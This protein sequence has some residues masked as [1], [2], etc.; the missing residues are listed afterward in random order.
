MRPWTAKDDRDLV[1]CYVS[2]LTTHEIAEILLRSEPAISRRLRDQHN[3]KPYTGSDHV[4]A[5]GWRGGGQRIR[6]AATCVLGMDRD[7]AI[8]TLLVRKNEVLECY[9]RMLDAPNPGGNSDARNRIREVIADINNT[10]EAL[11]EQ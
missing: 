8:A 10:I 11:Y 5:S 3:L 2:G 9:T 1:Q 7:T 6:T 4:Q